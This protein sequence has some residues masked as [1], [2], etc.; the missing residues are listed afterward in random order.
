MDD[1]QLITR[2]LHEW[3]LANATGPVN[4]RKLLE[5]AL[6]LLPEKEER[7]YRRRSHS[8]VIAVAAGP[9]RSILRPSEME[10]SSFH[11]DLLRLALFGADRIFTPAKSTTA[12]IEDQA[13]VL[14]HDDG[15][16]T[17]R[18]NG[19]GNLTLKLPLI[20]GGHGMVVI[21]ENVTDVLTA[22]L[23][24]AVAVLD[25]TD[26]TQRITHVALAATLSGSNNNVVWRKQREQDASPNSYNMGFGQNGRKPVHLT[27]GV[28]PRPALR[29]Q[30]GEL[31][32]DLV[33]LLRREW[34]SR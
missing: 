19:Q 1:S 25:R 27:P 4:E 8:L 32:E 21:E 9:A 6:S 20:E 18:V 30:A 24:Y 17:V 34:R 10:R 11:D 28:R 29:H 15:A 26:P 31:V 12:A 5:Q 7:R 22:A 3:E 14:T 33:T 2:R 13:L 23:R 16:G